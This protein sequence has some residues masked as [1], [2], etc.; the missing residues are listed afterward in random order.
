MST[1]F[2]LPPKLFDIL[3]ILSYA[4]IALFAENLRVYKGIVYSVGSR[5]LALPCLTGSI[6]D[7]ERL[8]FF[9]ERELLSETVSEHKW[10][11][12]SL[13]HGNTF[14]LV[15]KRLLKLAGIIGRPPPYD[16]AFDGED[17]IRPTTVNISFITPGSSETD[18]QDTSQ[19]KIWYYRALTTLQ[20]L[21]HASIAVGL[22]LYGLLTSSLLI[23]CV[24]ASHLI[25]V[26]LR[27]AV[28]PTFAN[29]GAV[30]KDAAVRVSGG[31]ALDVHVVTS[32]WNADSID[33][34]CGYSS[35][36]HALTNLPAR[37]RHLRFAAR[38]LRL[39]T[40]VLAAQAAALASLAGA[41][42]ADV[43]G[44]AV[45]LV[46]YLA[47]QMLARTTTTQGRGA[48]AAAE[49]LGGGAVDV[50]PP[51]LFKRRRTALLFVAGLP[52]TPKAGTWSWLDPYMPNNPRRA[53]WL[54]DFEVLKEE[55]RRSAPGVRS[56]ELKG[57]VSDIDKVLSSQPLGSRLRAYKDAVGWSE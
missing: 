17:Y 9:S 3:R 22:G 38:A 18:S 21:A 32:D 23:S 26:A 35:H 4:P 54:A 36:L 29:R 8:W 56:S 57:V 46:L 10:S 37:L 48:A 45:W 44:P 1:S 47:M 40:L 27:A 28:S 15:N 31:A 41:Q 24:V 34:V 30:A 43:A 20:L 42:S 50:L 11:V 25:L 19:P 52:V 55:T 7:I 33:V 5:C 13:R 2:H 14:T 51:L 49:L 12:S 39:L 16:I 53:E 6:N